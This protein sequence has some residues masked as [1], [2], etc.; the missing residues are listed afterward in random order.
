MINLLDRLKQATDTGDKA[1]AMASLQALFEIA[2][3]FVAVAK[4]DYDDAA[5]HFI[6]AAQW[7]AETGVM[8]A[9]EELAAGGQVQ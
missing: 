9:G 2:M 1:R 5:H 8:L 4:Q 6:R 3:A 7:S